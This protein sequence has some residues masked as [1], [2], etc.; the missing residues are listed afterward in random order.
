MPVRLAEHRFL[1]TDEDVSNGFSVAG[2]SGGRKPKQDSPA[3]RCA[4]LATEAGGVAEDQHVAPSDS[5][6][7]STG[8]M[9]VLVAAIRR[10]TRSYRPPRRRR[11]HGNRQDRVPAELGILKREPVPLQ[12]D[13]ALAASQHDDLVPLLIS[14]AP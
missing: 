1:L 10:D 13:Q 7:R 11:H 14:C 8:T 4:E 6:P 2:S 9:P 3:Q 5:F 12:L